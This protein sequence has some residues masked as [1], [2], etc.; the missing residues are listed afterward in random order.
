MLSPL[1]YL[2]SFDWSSTFI[3]ASLGFSMNTTYNSTN[4]LIYK[5]EILEILKEPIIQATS[6]RGIVENY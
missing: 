4:D 5:Y 6:I 1:A 3:S 2:L